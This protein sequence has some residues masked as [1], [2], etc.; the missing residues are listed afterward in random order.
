MMKRLVLAALL[1]VSVFTV[2]TV[3]AAVPV[4]PPTCVPCPW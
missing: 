3:E 2:V 4:P 1:A